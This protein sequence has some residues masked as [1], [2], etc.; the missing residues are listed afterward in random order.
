MKLNPDSFFYKHILW[1]E[2]SYNRPRNFCELVKNLLFSLTLRL[3]LTALTIFFSAFL[4][5]GFWE[6]CKAVYYGMD[7][8]R[9][10]FEEESSRG[11]ALASF[12]VF[13][14]LAALATFYGVVY[15]IKKAIKAYKGKRAADKAARVA[16]TG[17]SYPCNQNSPQGQGMCPDSV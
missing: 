11:F 14:I 3:I 16:D 10:L 17:P 15:G 2:S 4:L 1:I 6:F 8:V 13:S 9:L 5:N 12:V 7:Y